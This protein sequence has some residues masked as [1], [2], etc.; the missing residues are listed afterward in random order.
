MAIQE[1][2]DPSALRVEALSVFWGSRVRQV[3]TITAVADSAGSLDDTGFTVYLPAGY[4]GTVTS[5]TIGFNETTPG[6][7]DYDVTISEGA[8]ATAVAEAIV[9]ALSGESWVNSISNEDEVISLTL[10]NFG[11][12]TIPADITGSAAGFSYAIATSG[13]EL[14]DIGYTSEDITINLIG[15]GGLVDITSHQ[16]GAR[17]IGAVRTGGNTTVALNFAEVSRT[18]MLERL[19]NAGGTEL[20]LSDA[21]TKAIGIGTVNDFDNV[22]SESKILVLHPRRLPF[23]DHSEDI[24]LWKTY[25][26]LGEMSFS[27]ENQF[28]LPASFRTF[29]DRTKSNT[30][31]IGLYGDW[32]DSTFWS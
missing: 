12:A 30:Y 15:E 3:N 25:P 11:L 24:L 2:L 29:P 21:S 13:E 10:E 6:T 17:V 27:G 20:T 22:Y 5:Y 23:S 19:E 28:V 4:D 26:E 32:T 18:K 7:F 16:S 1:S 9:S 8:T 14:A 31:N